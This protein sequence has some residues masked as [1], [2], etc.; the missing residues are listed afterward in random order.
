MLHLPDDY[1]EKINYK[2]NLDNYFESVN[3]KQ[4]KT[5]MLSTFNVIVL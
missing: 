1:L 4:E 5:K 2:L 3:E